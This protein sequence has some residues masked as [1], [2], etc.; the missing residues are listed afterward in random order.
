M[1][2]QLTGGHRLYTALFP[3]NGVTGVPYYTVV[4]K[5]G[6]IFKTQQSILPPKPPIRYGAHTRSTMVPSSSKPPI[7]YGAHTKSTIVPSSSKPPIKYDVQTKSTIVP[8]SSKPPVKYDV[9][10]KSTIVPSSSK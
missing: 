3:V 9:Q 7:R 4:I 8:S 2:P 1:Q 6:L 10:T 5:P